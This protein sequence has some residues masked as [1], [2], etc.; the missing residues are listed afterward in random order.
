MDKRDVDIDTESQDPTDNFGAAGLASALG[1][2]ARPSPVGAL[3]SLPSPSASLGEPLS[4]DSSEAP[5]DDTP[6]DSA[7]AGAPD[8]LDGETDTGTD[9]DAL[10]AS[11]SA[12][13][14]PSMSTSPLKVQSASDDLPIG[15]E[16]AANC[17][18]GFIGLFFSTFFGGHTSD[19]AT[20]K[21]QYTYYKDF[22]MWVS[23]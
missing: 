16:D 21:D 10:D 9:A 2:F 8:V 15:A 23:E 18:V 1:G 5:V 6:L 3:A 22:Q 4:D 17:G 19:W 14:L 13:P 12:S 7:T 11:S 20:P